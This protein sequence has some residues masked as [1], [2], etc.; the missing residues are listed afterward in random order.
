M[1]TATVRLPVNSAAPSRVSNIACCLLIF[2]SY[3][4]EGTICFADTRRQLPQS[5]VRA[6]G[7]SSKTFPA[8]A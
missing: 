4:K 1:L 6:Y 5:E 8:S 7:H 3:P 2:F